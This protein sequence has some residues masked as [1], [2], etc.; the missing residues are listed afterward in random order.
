MD[1]TAVLN[2]LLLAEYSSIAPRLIE[3][4]TFVPPAWARADIVVRRIAAASR[5][6]CAALTELILDLGGTPAP[7]RYRAH[8]ADLHYLD[9]GS[10]VPK[11]EEDQRAIVETYS[12]AVSA[13]AHLPRVSSMLLRMLDSHQRDLKALEEVIV[14]P[15]PKAA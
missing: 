7:R 8:T 1:E 13:L 6:N 12:R 10:M 5:E 9:M 3:S 11:L 4:T 15:A 2:D 14:R